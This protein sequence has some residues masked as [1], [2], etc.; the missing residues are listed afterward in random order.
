MTF[1]FRIF[2][3]LF[4]FSLLFQCASMESKENTEEL[5]QVFQSDFDKYFGYVNNQEWDNLMGMINPNLFKI[6][7]KE[8]IIQM[9]A[10]LKEMG[11]EMHI[12]NPKLKTFSDIIEYKGAS[13]TKINYFANITMGLNEDLMANIDV[14]MEEM[15]TVYPK[16]DVT[17]SME[18]NEILIDADAHIVAMSNDGYESWTYF[19]VDDSKMEI[20]KRLIPPVVLEKLLKDD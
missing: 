19:E 3:Y 15:Y 6:A 11:I 1:T 9:F 16:E 14:M 18:Q 13:Y 5:K 17:L 8:S 7:P 12:S 2:L 4:S 10:S 20:L